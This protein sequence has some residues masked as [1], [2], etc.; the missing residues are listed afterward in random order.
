MLAELRDPEVVANLRTAR[1]TSS[2]RRASRMVTDPFP[3]SPASPMYAHTRASDRHASLAR[4]PQNYGFQNCS[5]FGVEARAPSPRP[6]SSHVV[7]DCAQGSDCAS[8]SV[9]AGRRVCTGGSRRESA[10]PGGGEQRSGRRPGPDPRSCERGQQ[11]GPRYCIQLEPRFG[12]LA[13][14][15]PHDV[16]LGFE[17][18]AARASRCFWRPRV[19]HD[20]DRLDARG[21]AC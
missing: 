10:V 8:S 6:L 2:S 11:K 14:I 7:R 13:V 16:G 21:V 4:I 18:E 20:D 3:S 9:P 17:E 5:R 12:G 19:Q 1:L 15:S